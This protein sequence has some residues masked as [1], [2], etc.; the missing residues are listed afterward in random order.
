MTL[1]EFEAMLQAQQFGEIVSVS[2]EA[3]YA[4]G[5]HQH[6]FEACAYITSGDITLVVKGIATRY[7]AGD[8]FRLAAGVA[9]EESAG[10]N[11]V[12]YRAGRR[13]VLA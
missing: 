13:T 11:G 6:P 4:L 2:R 10:L 9:H 12:S 3:G 7:L 1:T 5:D 8:I